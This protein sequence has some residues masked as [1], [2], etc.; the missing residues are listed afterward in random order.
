MRRSVRAHRL[1]GRVLLGLVVVG[2]TLALGSCHRTPERPPNILWI[3]A[4]DMNFELGAYGD[5][6]ARTPNLDRL[7]AEGVR[8]TNVFATSPVC[9]PSRTALI[10]GVHATTIGAQHMRSEDGGYRPVPAP[11]VRTFTEPLRA[12]GYYAGN[13]LKLDYQFSG[14]VADAPP[15][16]WDEEAF[17]DWRHRDGDQPFFLYAT[18]LLT[19]ESRLFE[20]TSATTTDPARVVVP[21]YYPDTPAVRADFALHYD[22][23]AAMD[24][25]V[26]ELLDRL[27]AEGLADDTIVFFFADNGRGFPRDKRS[28]YDG[29]IH[30]PL[31]VRWPGHLEPGTSNDELV[32]FLDFAPTVLALAGLPIPEFMQGRVF[33]GERAAPAPEFVFASSDRNDEAVDRVR[34]VR[35]RRYAYVRNYRPELPYGQ[36]I[37]YRESLVTMQEIRRLGALDQLEPPADWFFRA[38]K[39][40]EELYDTL[41]DPYQVHDLAT[42][43]AYGAIL[44][45]MRDAHE[46]WVLDSGDT[47]AIPEAELA[48]RFWPSGV[49]PTTPP[50]SFATTSA[51]VA[52]VTETAGASIAYR[53]EGEDDLWRLYVDPIRVTRGRTVRAIAV[54]YGWAPSA[55]A[56][57]SVE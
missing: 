35:D 39:P 51:G 40:V 52:I 33:L 16:N 57:F 44:A 13:V 15:T 32:S 11:E 9:A 38:T 6:L 4:E 20:D 19:H 29:G 5:P 28:V 24:T 3:V 34:A 10:T 53:I 49:R 31:I 54:R 55:A 14:P 7:A 12:H 1:L 50:P 46:R 25:A 8:Y 23:V 36:T 17:G 48:E 45:R 27:E 22:N 37:T 2:S 42:D 47:G 30:E 41:V 43:P 21:P 56:V 18:S 26:G